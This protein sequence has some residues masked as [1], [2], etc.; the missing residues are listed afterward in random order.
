MKT[1]VALLKLVKTL[2][3]GGNFL[4][5]CFCQMYR[6]RLNNRNSLNRKEIIKNHQT[7]GRKKEQMRERTWGFPIVT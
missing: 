4:K 5:I 7:S 6:K 2:S 3:D 1:E